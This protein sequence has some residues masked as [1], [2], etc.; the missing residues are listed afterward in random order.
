MQQYIDQ[1]IFDGGVLVLAAHG[2]LAKANSSA[3]QKYDINKIMNINGVLDNYQNIR[4]N[5]Y[6]YKKQTKE[7]LEWA[8]N[9]NLIEFDPEDFL[10]LLKIAAGV[11]MELNAEMK[12]PS[13]KEKIFRGAIF[14]PES[15]NYLNRVS[16]AKLNISS[17]LN[18]LSSAHQKINKGLPIFEKKLRSPTLEYLISETTYLVKTDFEK[19]LRSPS[20]LKID[21]NFSCHIAASYFWSSLKRFS[22]FPAYTPS[23]TP[24]K[25][26]EEITTALT[27]LYM[28]L[29]EPKLINR[30]FDL[31]LS[32][33]MEEPEKLN[34]T[35]EQALWD[36]LPFTLG[37]SYLNSDENTE[38]MIFMEDVQDQ[39]DS[40]DSINAIDFE[41][42]KIGFKFL[43]AN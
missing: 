35:T 11:R 30:Y 17:I 21:F 25:I 20:N 13:I 42:S 31:Y 41:F 26:I 3:R 34:S 39:L 18:E 22:I 40:F 10:S 9:S 29:I 28:P 23:T 16:Q 14:Q 32:H 37:S 4:P 1:A 12:P 8:I 19:K 43:N 24:Q 38:I 2:V 5:D 33:A 36:H 27:R 7:A 6:L 15:K